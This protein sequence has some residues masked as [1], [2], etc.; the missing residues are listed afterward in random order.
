M[1][2]KYF[3]TQ[4][5]FLFKLYIS[6]F[7]C[8]SLLFKCLLMLFSL[9][10][11]WKIKSGHLSCITL[12]IFTLNWQVTTGSPILSTSVWRGGPNGTQGL[13]T[14][15]PMGFAQCWF[16]GLCWNKRPHLE[17]TGLVL[18]WSALYRTSGFSISDIQKGLMHLTDCH[19]FPSVPV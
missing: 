9:Q 17:A 12:Q 5:F 14:A 11:V 3:V 13:T 16:S 19:Q 1:Q 2:V 7:I 15:P 18:S 8:L 4:F 6:K 10:I